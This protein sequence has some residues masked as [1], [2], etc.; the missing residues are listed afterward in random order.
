MRESKIESATCWEA[1]EKGWKSF[2]WSSPGNSGV[3]DRIFLKLLRIV[4]VEFKA[5]GKKPNK[6]QEHTLNLIKDLGFHVCVIDNVEDGKQLFRGS[7]TGK[8][9][10]GRMVRN[11]LFRGKDEKQNYGSH[12]HD[13]WEL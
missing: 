11:F 7:N 9:S 2:K 13:D 1:K 5:P 3:P 12:S 10:L 8:V 4:F 6:L